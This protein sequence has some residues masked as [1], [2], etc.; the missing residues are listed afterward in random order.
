MTSALCLAPKPI[1]DIT[2]YDFKVRDG[3]SHVLVIAMVLA[4][5]SP[6]VL[7]GAS[8]GCK[9][10]D[11][12]GA[13]VIDKTSG[14]GGITF[15]ANVVSI[16]FNGPDWA[17]L[18]GQCLEYHARLIDPAGRGSDMQEGAIEVIASPFV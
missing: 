3:E 7:T 16:E 5:G 11:A 18:A 12:A 2:R 4:D 1:D 6:K 10:L 13:E 9:V 8:A 17:G 15:A 14:G